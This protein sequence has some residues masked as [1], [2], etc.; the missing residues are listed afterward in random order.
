MVGI[1]FASCRMYI[2][3]N[4]IYFMPTPNLTLISVSQIC[5]G[6]YVRRG[7]DYAIFALCWWYIQTECRHFLCCAYGWNSTHWKLRLLQPSH[8]NDVHTDAG[9]ALNADLEAIFFGGRSKQHH[10]LDKEYP[11]TYLIHFHRC[12]WVWILRLQLMV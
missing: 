11:Y 7:D 8:D 12:R 4:L 5:F 10:G 2:I 1:S 9:C 3:T 6:S